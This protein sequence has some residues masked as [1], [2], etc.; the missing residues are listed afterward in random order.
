LRVTAFETRRRLILTG[1]GEIAV[2]NE[3]VER[4]A[5]RPSRELFRAS[6]SNAML[7]LL[8]AFASDAGSYLAVL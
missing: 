1:A 4:H 3:L 8:G 6:S 7:P 5:D 2:E